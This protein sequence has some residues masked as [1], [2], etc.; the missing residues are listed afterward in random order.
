MSCCAG[1]EVRPSGGCR[2]NSAW[3]LGTLCQAVGGVGGWT[4]SG[5]F[6]GGGDQSPCRLLPTTASLSSQEIDCARVEN[7]ELR[8]LDSR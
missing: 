6:D 2:D 8:M 5:L 3:F 4:P 1:S 7:I